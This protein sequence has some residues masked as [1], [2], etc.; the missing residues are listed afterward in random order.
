[1]IEEMGLGEVTTVANYEIIIN[2][3]TYNIGILEFIEV[4]VWRD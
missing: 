3:K 4:K 1:M 2:V